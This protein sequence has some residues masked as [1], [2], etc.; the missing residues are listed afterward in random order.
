MSKL[1]NFVKQKKT[2]IIVL[3]I[4]FICSVAIAVGV[5]TQITHENPK[6]KKEEKENANYEDLKNN[7]QRIFTNAINKEETAALDINYENILYTR[8]NVQ[9][10]N[11][12]YSINAK[13]PWFKGDSEVTAKINDEILNIFGAE[14][15]KIK[16]TAKVYTTYDVDYA[17]YVNS[18]II[19]LVIMC[20]YK[21]GASAQRMMVQCYNYDIKNDKLLTIEDVINYKNLTK[22]EIQRKTNKE[23]SKVNNQMKSIK[24]QGYNVYLRDENSDI[25]K[26]EN[27]TNFFLGQNNYLYLVYAYGN[28]NYTSELD[29]VIF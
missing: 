5:Y 19:S 22:E 17:A 4:L 25:Y 23:I 18:N 2:I 10:E 6:N 14:V 7:F 24:E 3:V 12:K 9:E 29:L 16:N 21:N 15:V 11:G 13:I 1:I 8:F 20:K 27:T 28:N 26:V